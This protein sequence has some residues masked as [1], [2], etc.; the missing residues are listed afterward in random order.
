MG[1][2]Q[3]MIEIYQEKKFLE[4]KYINRKTDALKLMNQK[5]KDT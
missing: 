1:F 3:K 4:N 5:N 2:Y